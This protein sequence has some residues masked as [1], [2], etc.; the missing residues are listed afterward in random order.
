[1][2]DPIEVFADVI[3]ELIAFAGGARGPLST[4]ELQAHHAAVDSAVQ[5]TAAPAEAPAE[6]A[7][8][9]Q[10]VSAMAH[11]EEAPSGEAQS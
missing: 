4:A 5:A 8:A 10:P 7:P 2:A 3:H 6:Q 9:D 11:A 1:M